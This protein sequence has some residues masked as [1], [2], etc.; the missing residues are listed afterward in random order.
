MGLRPV[1][2]FAMAILIAWVAAAPGL[3]Q[4]ARSDGAATRQPEPSV[5]LRQAAKAG[6]AEVARIVRPNRGGEV[7]PVAGL[8]EVIPAAVGATES[9][10]EVPATLD[11]ASAGGGLDG[12]AL[13]VDYTSVEMI[14]YDHRGLHLLA[15]AGWEALPGAYDTVFELSIPDTEFVGFVQSLGDG[16]FPGVLA[17]VLFRSFPELLVAA[18]DPHAELLGVEMF[19]TDQQLP[20]VKVTLRAEI[21]GSM[22]KGAIYL[23]SP[24]SEAYA[25]FGF[26]PPGMWT[27][28]EPGVDRVAESVYFDPELITLTTAENGPLPYIDSSGVLALTA[29]QDWQLAE[30]F[31]PDFPLVVVDPDFT[32]TGLLGLAPG[33]PADEGVDL[34]ALLLGA[35]GEPNAQVATEMVETIRQEMDVAPDEFVVDAALTRLFPAQTSAVLRFGGQGRFE[36]NIESPVVIYVKIDAESMVALLFFGDAAEILEQEP[37]ILDLVGSV[38]AQ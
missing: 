24:G 30:T 3:A 16:E 10:D 11:A 18:I 21:E 13:A 9:Q 31:D 19:M 22:A 12:D 5:D 26:A 35:E 6:V 38:Q 14:P 29:P 7:M 1:C 25:L 23:V 32:I 2:Q 27:G 37:A 34:N 36:E 20:V 8:R 4:A 33:G 28:V 15:P 17:V